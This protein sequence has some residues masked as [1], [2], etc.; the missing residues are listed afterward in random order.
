MS[1]RVTLRTMNVLIRSAIAARAQFNQEL[2]L[3]GYDPADNGARE[4]DGEYV[5]LERRLGYLTVRKA[6]GHDDYP[7]EFEV[8]IDVLD[9]K[10]TVGQWAD[11]AITAIRAAEQRAEE[12]RRQTA[13][14][15]ERTMLQL[16]LSVDPNVSLECRASSR[17]GSGGPDIHEYCADRRACVCPCHQTNEQI[18]VAAGIEVPS[19]EARS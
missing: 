7:D 11:E 18:A 3:A 15:R 19:A 4:A 10:R 14:I 8:P 2:L 17:S 13:E 6:Y 16:R 1:T 9:G 12:F 5:A